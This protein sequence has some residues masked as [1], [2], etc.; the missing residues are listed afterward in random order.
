MN[1]YTGS[2]S[3]D[4]LNVYYFMNEKF[5]GDPIRSKDYEI[6]YNWAETVPYPKLNKNNFSIRWFG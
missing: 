4:G 6:N 2:E 5:N 1:G 3:G